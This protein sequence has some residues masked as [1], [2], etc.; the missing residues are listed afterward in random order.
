M[1]GAAGEPGVAV[2]GSGIE[3]CGW[4]AWS[5]HAWDRSSD[6]RVGR[7]SV[8]RGARIGKTLWPFYCTPFFVELGNLE[9]HSHLLV[10]AIESLGLLVKLQLQL[11][12]D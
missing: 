6:Y 12:H 7:R 1:A 2:H 3:C 4:T 8:H 9:S 11:S 5:V 10:I